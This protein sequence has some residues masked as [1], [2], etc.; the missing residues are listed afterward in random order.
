M[1]KYQCTI[2][3]FI[4]D[5]ETEEPRKIKPRTAFETLPADWV[6][7]SCGVCGRGIFVEIE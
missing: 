1:T 6:C 7:T 5:T 3:N 4:F 2:C